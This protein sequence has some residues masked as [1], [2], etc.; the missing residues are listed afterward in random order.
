MTRWKQAAL[1]TMSAGAMLV[2][3]ALLPW[4]TL[5][6]GFGSASIMGTDGDGVFALGLGVFIA[7]AGFVAFNGS[8]V[9]RTLAA[10]V[11]ILAVLLMGSTFMNMGEAVAD[12][13]GASLGVGMWV[14]GLGA[15]LGVAAPLGA[16]KAPSRALAVDAA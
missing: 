5:T 2:V 11:G 6:S 10:I 12:T 14:A 15:L 4:A 13:K 9:A 8:D 16:G 3:G 7:V 1:L